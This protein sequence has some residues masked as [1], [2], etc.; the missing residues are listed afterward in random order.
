MEEKGLRVN[1][2]KTKIMI[3]GTG[4]ISC[5]VQVSSHVLSVALEWAAKASSAK[6]VS[7]GCIR[8][9]VGSSA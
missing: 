7:T 2:G 6:A 5:R 1:A 8:S 4:W 3:C 9:A